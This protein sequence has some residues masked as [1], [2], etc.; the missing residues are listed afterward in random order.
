MPGIQDFTYLNFGKETT[1]GTPV[2]PTRKW[3]G[4]ST[5]VLD[6]DPSLNFHTG[7]NRGRRS[8]I[9]RATQQ[10]EDATLKIRAEPTFDDMVWPLTQLKGGLTGTGGAADKTW[11]AAP[12]MTAANSPEAFSVDVGDD[13]RRIGVAST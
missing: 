7:E 11:A 10:S 9:A 12:S 8:V 1:R 4:E 3:I 5:G 2:A 6:V 13:V